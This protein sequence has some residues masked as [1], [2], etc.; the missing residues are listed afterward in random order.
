MQLGEPSLTVRCDADPWGNAEESAVILLQ[1]RLRFPVSESLAP[2]LFSK[3]CR[4]KA[5]FALKELAEVG[6]FVET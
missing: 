3:L 4:G 6:G 5:D 1:L 2:L